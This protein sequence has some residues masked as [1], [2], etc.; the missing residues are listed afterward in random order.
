MAVG[1][2]GPT[3]TGGR[4]AQKHLQ[5]WCL[6]V[7]LPRLRFVTIPINTQPEE[8]F[9]SHQPASSSPPP[10]LLASL[11]WQCYLLNCK[12]KKKQNTYRGSVVTGQEESRG[13]DRQRGKKCFFNFAS[14][15]FVN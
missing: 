3:S 9:V 11:F 1:R 10:F 13:W 2:D 5:A 15:V 7:A 6:P 12:K 14:N 8:C 4:R